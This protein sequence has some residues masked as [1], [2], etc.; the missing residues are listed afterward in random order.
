MRRRVCCVLKGDGMSFV[1]GACQLSH[2]HQFYL[3]EQLIDK[4]VIHTW[5]LGRHFLK[6][7]QTKPDASRKQLRASVASEKIQAF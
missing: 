7:G 6:N 4:Y 1:G 3:K 2:E 5:V